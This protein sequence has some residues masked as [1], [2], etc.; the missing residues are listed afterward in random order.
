MYY[1]SV[2]DLLSIKSVPMH[3]LIV[4]VIYILIQISKRY[5]VKSPNWWDWLYYLGLIGMMLPVFLATEENQST[6][7]LIADIG[8]PFL[9]IPMLFD[10]VQLLR[11]SK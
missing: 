8:A 11:G 3:I 4:T 5:A 7:H 2:D 9:V 1:W 6:Y 10:I